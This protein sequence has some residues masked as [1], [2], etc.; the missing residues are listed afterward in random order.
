MVRWSETASSA[1]AGGFRRGRRVWV[2]CYVYHT[3]WALHQ[4]EGH[5]EA[6]G[7]WVGGILDGCVVVLQDDRHC[8][9]PWWLRAA[10]CGRVQL[11]GAGCAV[12]VCVCCTEACS[13]A[14]AWDSF[15][16]QPPLTVTRLL[17]TPLRQ[18]KPQTPVLVARKQRHA[19]RFPLLLHSCGWLVGPSLVPAYL[20]ACLPAMQ[21]TQYTL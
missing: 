9:P 10:A 11:K 4:R 21:N 8:W 5:V 12:C 18:H 14:V 15:P 17:I 19:Y 13:I 2:W 7:E 6:Q 3:R 1:T 20:P 16:V